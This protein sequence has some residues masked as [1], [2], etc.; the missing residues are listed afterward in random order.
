M[1]PNVFFLT[2]LV[3]FDAAGHG[4]AT[5]GETDLVCLPLTL[6]GYDSRLSLVILAGVAMPFLT[7][8]C[9]SST[10][11]HPFVGLCNWGLDDLQGMRLLLFLI[12]L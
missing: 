5:V 9:N 1:D 8:V 7:L 3:S 10:L 11:L 12:P 4:F 6:Q 2:E